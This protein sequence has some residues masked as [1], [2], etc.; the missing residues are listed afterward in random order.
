VDIRL[1]PLAAAEFPQFRELLRAEYVRSLIEDAGL[2]REAAE[3]KAAGD[4]EAL[5][6]G[7]RPQSQHRIHVL[8]DQASGDRVGHLFWSPRRPTGSPAERAYLYEL[9]IDEEFRGQGLGTRAL[10]LLESEARAEGLPGIDL[11]VWGG[12]EHARALYRK[13]GFREH[14]VFMSKELT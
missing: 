10:E 11:N 13:A 2:S 6:A 12:N 9:F 8:E 3:A 7:G 4:H 1:R 14:A 5:F